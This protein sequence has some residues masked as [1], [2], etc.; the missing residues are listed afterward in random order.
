M[1]RWGAIL[2]LVLLLA[3]NLSAQ[4]ADPV[5]GHTWVTLTGPYKMAFI[6]GAMTMLEAYTGSLI[7]QGIDIDQIMKKLPE[8]SVQEIVQAM[9]AYYEKPENLNWPVSLAFL[10]VTDK[11]EYWYPRSKAEEELAWEEIP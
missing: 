11:I 3:G 5:D 6:W 9:E 1:K 10:K 7:W 8:M 4:T 2:V